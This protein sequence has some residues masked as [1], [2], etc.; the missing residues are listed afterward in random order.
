MSQSE[1]E[2]LLGAITGGFAGVHNRIDT[3]KDE[4]NAHKS[5][6]AGI[7]AEIALTDA[8]RTERELGKATALCAL[9]ES[10]A[11]ELKSRINWGAVKTVVVGAIAVLLATAAVKILF[12]NLGQWKW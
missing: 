12:T 11:K 8:V 5:A 9:E 6:C 3:F 7:F 4:F 10:K 1:Y 2:T